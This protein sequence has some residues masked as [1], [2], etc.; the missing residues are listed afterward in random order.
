MIDVQRCADVG[1]TLRIDYRLYIVPTRVWAQ[2]RT[3]TECIGTLT[4]QLEVYQAR[5][6]ELERELRC[7]R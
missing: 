2:F 3:M 6:A 7:R 4:R 5:N 1:K